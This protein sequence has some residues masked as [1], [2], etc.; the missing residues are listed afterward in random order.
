M[1]IALVVSLS[2]ALCSIPA[3]AQK[4][5][6]P[7]HVVIVF[8]ENKSYEDIVNSPNAPYLTKLATQTGASVTFYG[9][10]HPSQPNY[11]E[12]FAGTNS[13]KLKDGTTHTVVN[14]DCFSPLA[15]SR[16]LGGALIARYGAN[17]FRGYGEGFNKSNPT[18]CTIQNVYYARKHCPWTYFTDSVSAN[19]TFDDFPADFTKLPLVSMV[20]PNLIHDMHSLP[21]NKDFNKEGDNI[22]QLV[23]NGDDWLQKHLDA[24]V[25]WAMTHNS[26]LIVTFDENSRGKQE[27]HSGAARFQM[28]VNHVATIFV[29]PMVQAKSNGQPVAY[30]HWDLLK[31][32]LW[33]YG[34]PPVGNA[35]KAQVI[36]GIWK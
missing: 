24:Y 34:L 30:N 29:G 26:L 9:F 1:K 5:P 20:T 10:H 28:P 4:V 21:G 6:R 2:L 31:T 27:G 35:A 15:T 36:E 17:G 22:P 19:A 8:E 12:F 13:I 3:A 32:I 25:Q 33:M 23:K 16:S 14:D 18:A 7:D 11:F